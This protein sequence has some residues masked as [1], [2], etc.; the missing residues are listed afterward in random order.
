MIRGRVFST[1]KTNRLNGPAKQNSPTPDYRPVDCDFTDEIEFLVVNKLPVNITFF[2]PNGIQL[3]ESGLIT[4][5]FAQNS[6]DFLKL[7][8]GR[9]IRLD[10]ILTLEIQEDD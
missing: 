2:D 9:V 1:T 7:E 4:D 3:N 5:I 6:E 8:N 10:R